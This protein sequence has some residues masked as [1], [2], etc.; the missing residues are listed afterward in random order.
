MRLEKIKLAG[1]KSFVE[2][3]TIV[4]PKRLIGIVGPNGCGKSN[5]IDAVRWVMGESSAKHLR[6][7]AM[8]DVIFNG[9]TSRKPVGLASVELIFDNSEGRLGGEYARY[10]QIAL[11][12]QVSRDGQSQYFLNGTRCRR[13]DIMDVFLGTGLGPRSYAIIEQ[14][15]V[16]RFVEAKP[17]ELRLFIEEAAGLS[18]YKERRHETELKMQHTR[19]NLERLEDIRSELQ[20]QVKRLER[21]AKKA[22]KYRQLEQAIQQQQ[23]ELLAIRWREANASH[24]DHQ[25]K[26]Q[27]LQQEVD[28]KTTALH[29]LEQALTRQHHTVEQTQHQ[30]HDLQAQLY[31]L[32]SAIGRCDQTIQHNQKT[33]EEREK[34]LKAWREE[35]Q[36]L[37]TASQQ[38]RQQQASYQTQSRQLEKE[39]AKARVD[40]KTAWR[41]REKEEK[42]WHRL[43]R[44]FAQKRDELSRKKEQLELLRLEIR[45]LRQ[46]RE[47]TH[48]RLNRLREE[49]SQLDQASELANLSHLEQSLADTEAAIAQHGEQ[50]Q[51][52]T[53]QM[54]SLRQTITEAQKELQSLHARHSQIQGEISALETLQRHALGKDKPKLQALLAQHGWDS[55]PRLAEHLQTTGGWNNAVETVLAEFLEAVCIEDLDGCR[56][57]AGRLEQENATFFHGRPAEVC[58]APDALAAKIQSP[59]SL[60]SLVAG[61]RCCNSLEEGLRLRHQLNLPEYWVTP[62]GD[63]IGPDWIRLRRSQ[64]D[65]HG[66][67]ERQKVLRELK[68]QLAE[69]E[70]RQGRSQSA[71]HQYQTELDALEKQQESLRLQEKA[72]SQ[73]ASKLQAELSASRTRAEE[74]QRRATR[75]AEEQAGLEKQ[76]AELEQALSRQQT[77]LQ[78]L[79]QEEQQHSQGLQTLQN[80]S[81][82][83]RTAF[84]QA[85]N[86]ARRQR[87]QRQ[88]LEASLEHCQHSAQLLHQQLE[89]ALRH[90]RALQERL[91]K[92]ESQQAEGK[93]PLAVA[94]KELQ[95]LLAQRQPLEQALTQSREALQQ[96]ERRLQDL[97]ARHHKAQSELEQARQHLEQARLDA[98]TAR[99]KLVTVKEQAQESQTPLEG[100]LSQLPEDA[101]ASQWQ[102]KLEQTKAEQARL[103]D[104]NL[105]AIEEHRL[106]SERLRFLDKQFE[107]LTDS[108]A[109]LERAIRKI[110]RESRARFKETFNTIDGHFK[111]RF[112]ALFGGGEGKLELTGEDLLDAGVKIVAR[113]PGK[114]NSSIHLLSGGE[115]A[116]T[117]VALVFSFFELNP[118]PFCL[119]DEVDAPLDEA[120]VGRYCQL[121]QSM[122]ERV[123]FIFISHNKTTMEIAEQL[124][125]VT[126]REPGVSRIVAVDL[127]KAAQMAAA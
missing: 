59:W 57:L 28:G 122:S 13:R 87:E 120:N 89:R 50:L 90:Q 19:A 18:K 8:A 88:K 104:V 86:H 101:G 6:G 74:I 27:Q 110:D 71:L 24:Q 118:A 105:T 53:Q 35:L 127:E 106:H 75:M 34:S 112:P 37:E 21:Q 99:V 103:G 124:I 4:F 108:L 5:I 125:G 47:E 44:E 45:H 98:E 36:R 121:L 109:M 126:M 29:E 91:Q 93:T 41:Q 9:S 68:A 33:L 66:V 116:L 117:A 23:Q 65:S 43:R 1:F 49:Q 123:Q 73:Q 3:T 32:N 25:G 114:R 46:R 67:L 83:A 100:V 40:E 39:L 51:S 81:N 12:R 107:D 97:T 26:I 15:M 48:N 77:Q 95:S 70:K 31:E 61:A 38:D 102:A 119:L 52:V 115:K 54:Q 10:N 20:T 85:D 22:E 92:A 17:E 14:G 2:P 111:Q 84:D 76:L 56:R 72:H 79:E 80:Q 11:K 64:D 82:L 62:E 63:R 55:A 58:V 16:S 42:H 113:P 78:H 69:M 94:E 7:S 96:A 30:L 60:D